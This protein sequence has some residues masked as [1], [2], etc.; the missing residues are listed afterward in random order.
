MMSPK[1]IE[2]A[3]YLSLEAMVP[4]RTTYPALARAINWHHPQ[5]RGLGR[6][7]KEI[8]DFTFDHTCP[9]RLN[10]SWI[11][12][13]LSDFEYELERAGKSGESALVAARPHSVIA[14]V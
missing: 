2:I 5:G 3:R 14:E 4:Q 1:E 8:L 10:L 6:H 11:I 12:G 7:L 13:H 9:V